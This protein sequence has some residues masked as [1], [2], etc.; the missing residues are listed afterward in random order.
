VKP[1]KCIEPSKYAVA[2]APSGP[3]E[4]DSPIPI[5]QRIDSNPP[6]IPLNED[7]KGSPGIPE[8]SEA[9][10][11]DKKRRG[12]IE[13]T[14]EISTVM[15]TLTDKEQSILKELLQHGGTMTQTEI[16]YEMDISKSSLSGILTSMEKRKLITK[17]EKG[18]TNVIELSERFLNHKERS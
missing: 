10:W 5:E 14:S 9:S 2:P 11:P 6:A 8:N 12:G 13:L 7:T 4:L 18:R 16:R 3:G 1:E 15:D 17:K